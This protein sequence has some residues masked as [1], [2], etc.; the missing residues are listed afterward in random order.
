MLSIRKDTRVGDIRII[1]LT[2]PDEPLFHYAQT[3][4]YDKESGFTKYWFDT[5][6][7]RE[8]FDITQVGVNKRGEPVYEVEY[9]GST[10]VASY[11]GKECKS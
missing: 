4:V 6:G 3:I 8:E 9:V 1:T 10:I 11:R 2:K 7:N 5:K